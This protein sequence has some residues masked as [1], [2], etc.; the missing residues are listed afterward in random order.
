MPPEMTLGGDLS[1]EHPANSRREAIIAEFDAWAATYETERLAPWYQMHAREVFGQID[2][3]TARRV[4]DIGCGTGWALRQLAREHPD[5]E[6]HG[7]DIAPVM[8]AEAERLAQLE[9]LA[10][11]AFHHGDWEQMGPAIAQGRHDTIRPGFDLVLALSSLHY[12]ADLSATLVSIRDCLYTG[13]N[14][15]LVERDTQGSNLTRIWGAL[16]KFVLRDGVEFTDTEELL[17]MMRETGFASVRTL[18]RKRQMFRHG[19]LFTSVIV[20]EGAA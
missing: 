14:L 20:I 3:S 19:K 17:R 6:F 4:L 12:I 9:G 13:G 5:I 18:A 10:N 7:I 15:V 11:L 16:H 2:L 8:I 1:D